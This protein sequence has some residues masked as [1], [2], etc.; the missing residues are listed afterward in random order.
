MLCTKL[1]EIV[2]VSE[3]DQL[4]FTYPSSLREDQQ[5]DPGMRIDAMFANSEFMA[6]HNDAS[7][8]CIK[9]AENESLSGESTALNSRFV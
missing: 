8:V 2:P 4:L 9:E 6:Q 5:Q 1:E 7:L 3:G